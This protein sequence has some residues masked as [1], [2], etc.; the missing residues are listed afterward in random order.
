MFASELWQTKQSCLSEQRS[1]GKGGR[2]PKGTQQDVQMA[3][4][5]VLT[6]SSLNTNLSASDTDNE[7]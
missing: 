5:E 6:H 7:T 2:A 1:P 3:N 4:Y